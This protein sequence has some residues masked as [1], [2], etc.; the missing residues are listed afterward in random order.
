MEN[1]SKVHKQSIRSKYLFYRDNMTKSERYEKSIRIWERLKKEKDFGEADIVLVYMDY[2]SEVM[3]TGLVE[4]L[5]LSEN[6]KRVF[7]P[8]VEG[9]DIAFYE[10]DS[11]SDLHNGYQ[12]IREPEADP[13][14]LFTEKLFQEN[15]C[16][17]LVPGSVF[18]RNLSRM[19]YGK[20]FYDR[21]LQKFKGIP[22]AG[23]AF[24]CQIA[25]VPIPSDDNDVRLERVVTEDEVIK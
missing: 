20:G 16:F 2:R 6:R 11:F 19:G 12:G 25:P 7:A 3:T 10:I 23:I 17:L 22:N 15:K 13:K 4:E 9:L 8:V 1:R 18:D 24:S 21:F 14:K 5:F